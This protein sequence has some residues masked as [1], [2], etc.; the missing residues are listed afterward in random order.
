MDSPGR[1]LDVQR[2][3]YRGDPHYVPPMTVAER[4]QVDPA[5]NPFFAHAESTFLVAE[6]G[7]AIVGR[8]S[9]TRD[10]LH[11]E[12]HGD[13]IGFFGHF[14]AADEAAARAL[15][16]AAAAWLR[17][18]GAERLR[19]PV[20]LSTNYRCGLLID[21]ESGPPVV[22]MPYNPPIYARWLESCG[23]RKAKDLLALMVR[24]DPAMTARLDRVG[25]RLK[26]RTGITTRLLER[27]RF[28]AEIELLWQLYNRIWERNWGFV[29]M[30]Q[31]EFDRQAKEFRPFLQREDVRIAHKGEE[32]VGF[33][34]FL[35]DLNVP[36]KACNGRLL[37]LG[38]WRFWRALRKVNSTR[39]FTLGILPEFR[40]SGA[41]AILLQELIL[42]GARQGY[43]SCEASWLLEDNVPIIKAIEGVGGKVYRRYRVYE[44][45]L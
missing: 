28:A 30:S 31:R 4:W 41:D 38:W 12:F 3:F 14:E 43:R 1:F 44:M 34:I 19:G 24:W 15:L 40:K 27:A 6:R 39:V 32:P 9:A 20:D 42:G 33:A 25:A 5:R 36:I 29:P 7:G 10:R 22:Q 16:D 11:D 17:A 23:L 35:R 26:E 2:R 8:I 45:G 37:P 21:G 18:H 13:R